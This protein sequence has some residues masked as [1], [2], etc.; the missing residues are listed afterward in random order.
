MLISQPLWE[1]CV[2]YLEYVIFLYSFSRCYVYR[3]LLP[4]STIYYNK[5]QYKLQRLLFFKYMGPGTVTLCQAV[6]LSTSY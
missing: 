2:S 1:N 4:P 5:H 3:V 6:L